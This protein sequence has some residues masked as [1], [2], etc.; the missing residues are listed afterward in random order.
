VPY[1]AR[2]ANLDSTAELLQIRGI[3]PEL[4]YGAD[5]R[6]GLRDVITV[7]SVGQININTAGPLVLR[8]L[9]LSEAEISTVLQTRRD[10]PYAIVPGPMAG[11]GLTVTTRTFRVQAEGIVNGRVAARLTAVL[12]R[13]GDG[14]VSILEWSGVQ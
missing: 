3:T 6:P 4:F 13:Q 14:A 11:R 8:G 10:T 2:N 7:R 5:G 1:R 12:R 9:G